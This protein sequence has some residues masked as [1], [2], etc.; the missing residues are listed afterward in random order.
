MT[1]VADRTQCVVVVAVRKVVAAHERGDYAAVFVAYDPE[2]E[3]DLTRTQ[4]PVSDVTRPTE[5]EAESR[6][7]GSRT[8][9]CGLCPTA[10][11]CGWISSR[12]AMKR[13]TPRAAGV[14][15]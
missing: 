8:R 15:L 4:V 1:H 13:S 7:R 11:S 10:R 9:R 14:G 12:L 6:S 3:W 2:I 5:A